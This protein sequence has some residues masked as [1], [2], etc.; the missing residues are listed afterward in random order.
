MEEGPDKDPGTEPKKG[1]S[2]EEA[3]KL[4]LGKSLRGRKRAI[5]KVLVL[6]NSVTKS[7]LA[8]GVSRTRFYQYMESDPV[9]AKAVEQAREVYLEKLEAECDRRAVEG[10]LE[11]VGWHQGEPGAWVRRYSDI[12]LMF[13]MKKLD[14]SYRENA[15]QVNVNLTVTADQAFLAI[16]QRA[17]GQGP[18]QIEAGEGAES[19]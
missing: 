10:V 16:H 19:G 2:L 9:F 15:G 17:T 1:L 11:P 4:D 5:L 6:T 12:L 3:E 14:P 8:A 13:R 7:V 18:R